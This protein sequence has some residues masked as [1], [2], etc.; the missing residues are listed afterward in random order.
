MIVRKSCAGVIVGGLLCALSVGC[1]SNGGSGGTPPPPPSFTVTLS[2]TTITLLQGG[3]SQTVQVSATAQNGF[4]GTVS[5]TTAALPT[6]VTASP[7]SLSLTPGVP[8][9]FAFSAS[10]NALIAQQTLNVSATSGTLAVN[11][12]LQL[13]VTGAAVSDPLHLIGGTLVHGFYDETR[14]LLFVSNPGLNELDV[15]SGQDFSI[16]A[17]SACSPALGN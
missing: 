5:V 2:P 17:R 9:S 8:G 6:G 11:G 4:S 16:Q 12:S 3:A 13:M 7:T 1:G 14:K 10:S 15:V